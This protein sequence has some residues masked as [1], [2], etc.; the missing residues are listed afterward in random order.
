MSYRVSRFH[1]HMEDAEQTHRLGFK[2]SGGQL[3]PA[4]RSRAFTRH[5][6]GASPAIQLSRPTWTRRQLIRPGR[7]RA[8]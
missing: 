1:A 7:P 5:F 8:E 4:E 2:T 6:S 3:A